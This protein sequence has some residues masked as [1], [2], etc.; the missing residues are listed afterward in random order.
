MRQKPEAYLNIAVTIFVLLH[1][2]AFG[3]LSGVW[4]GAVPLFTVIPIV[5]GIWTFIVAREHFRR[6][7]AEESVPYR[8]LTSGD[9]YRWFFIVWAGWR[10]LATTYEAAFLLAAAVLINCVLIAIVIIGGEL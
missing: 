4:K 7:A 3:P 10:P 9:Y 5:L 2:F 1:I 6:G 8:R